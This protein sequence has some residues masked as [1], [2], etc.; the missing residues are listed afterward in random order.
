L[1]Q[2]DSAGSISSLSLDIFSLTDPQTEAVLHSSTL[3]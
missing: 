2:L 1:R 3:G